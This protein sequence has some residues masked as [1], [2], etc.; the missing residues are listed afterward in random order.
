MIDRIA[1]KQNLIMQLIT[2]I[3]W[4]RE[5]IASALKFDEI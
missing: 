4:R 2:T 5:V 1:L 3:F